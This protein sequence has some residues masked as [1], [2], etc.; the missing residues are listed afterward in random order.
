MQRQRHIVGLGHP[1]DLQ[2]FGNTTRMRQ[3]WLQDGHPTRFQHALEVEAREHALASG[4]RQVRVGGQACVAL[5]LFGQ[6]GFLNEK[7]TIRLQLFDEHLGHRRR[8]A[9]VKIEP[10]LDRIAESRANLR[11]L[12]HR[13]IHCAGGVDDAH[14]LAAVELEVVE[15]AGLQ[16]LHAGNHIRRTVAADP[17]VG[18]HLV[19]HETAEQLVHRHAQHLALDVPQRLVD[20]GDGAH[21]DRAAAVETGAIHGLPEVIDAARVLAD[22]VVGQLMHRRFH[23]ARTAFDDGLAPAGDAL[24]GFDLQEHPAR[25]QAIRGQASDFHGW[26]VRSDWTVRYAVTKARAR[27]AVRSTG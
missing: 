14:L 27:S 15:A 20:T 1:G 22:Q 25:R 18:A 10:E 8:N 12:R 26:I 5:G 11:H 16:R 9:A 19:A 13:R 3:V 17:A 2:A 4:N 7:R 24:V 6:H 21:Q 23:R